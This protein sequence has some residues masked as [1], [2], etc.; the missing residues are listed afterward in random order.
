[1]KSTVQLHWDYFLLL[2]KDLVTIGETIELSEG[3]FN[4]YGP[5][6][7]QL[8]LATG[9]ELDVALKS[10]ALAMCPQHAAAATDK[11]NMSHFKSMLV[12]YAFDQFTTAR[13]R[14]LRSDIVLT[15]WSALE[16]GANCTINWWVDYNNIK[17][18]RAECYESANLK[19]ALYLISAL[20]VVVAYISEIMM[21]AM[22]GFPQIIDWDAHMHMSQ[23]E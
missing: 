1:M 5:R 8:I 6:L 15:P 17:H 2:E 16:N 22:S 12:E 18:K 21:E 13:V 7:V 9:G 3:N 20:F 19:T 14:F 4:A 11:P 23:I 10:L